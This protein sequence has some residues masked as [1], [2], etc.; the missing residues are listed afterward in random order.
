MR[1]EE[2]EM[3]EERNTRPRAERKRKG[4]MERME[5]WRDWREWRDLGEM[6]RTNKDWVVVEDDV[7]RSFLISIYILFEFHCLF[8]GCVTLRRYS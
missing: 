8:W 4:E 1:G 6:A 2:S 3:G 7:N 5:D